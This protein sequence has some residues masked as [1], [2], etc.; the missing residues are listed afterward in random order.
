[1]HTRKRTKGRGSG[2]SQYING[3]RE[4]NCNVKLKFRNVLK[5]ND[6]VLVNILAN[7]GETEINIYL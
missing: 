6:E 2:I 5:P 7:L 3:S 4:S 1:M